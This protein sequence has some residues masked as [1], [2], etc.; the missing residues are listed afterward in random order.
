[1]KKHRIKIIPLLSL[2]ENGQYS[3]LTDHLLSQLDC[4]FIVNDIKNIYNR[5][6]PV[7]AAYIPKR[8]VVK[9]PVDFPTLNHQIAHMV[10]IEDINRCTINDWGFGEPKSE[11]NFFKYSNKMVLR[12]LSREIR[13]RAIQL[14]LNDKCDKNLSSIV[15]QIK[16][17]LKR[18]LDN[19]LGKFKNIQDLYQ[20]EDHLRQTTY[21]A[22][23]ED[24]IIHEW[25]R[26]ISFIKDWMETPSNNEE[27]VAA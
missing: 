15:N 2:V 3:K 26:R 12:I 16:H 23:N 4:R 11:K 8:S 7:Y 6:L 24:R 10:E 25:N 27:V 22:W 19:G 1:M 17:L 5:Q 13:V 20:W 18:R 14:H 21:D 9:I